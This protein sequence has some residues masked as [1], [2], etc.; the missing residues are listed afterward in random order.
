MTFT[1]FQVADNRDIWRENMAEVC[2][3]TYNRRREFDLDRDAGLFK[4]YLVEVFDDREPLD[5]QNIR[6]LLNSAINRAFQKEPQLVIRNPDDRFF[7]VIINDIPFVIDCE[8]TRF[9]RVETF[10]NSADSDRVMRRLLSD[11]KFI[12]QLW[13]PTN[14]QLSI[15]HLT[16]GEIRRLA[17]GFGMQHSIEEDSE[18]EFEEDNKT[19]RQPSERHAFRISSSEAYRFYKE[20]RKSDSL[21]RFLAIKRLEM[22]VS[23]D[24]EEELF[25]T[26]LSSIW[27]H[28]KVTSRGTWYEGLQSVL[29]SIVKVYKKGIDAVDSRRIFIENSN[30]LKR[31]GGGPI[32]IGVDASF[33]TPSL[34]EHVFTDNSKAFKLIVV[35]REDIDESISRFE[36]LDRHTGHDFSFIYRKINNRLAHL[37]VELSTSACANVVPRLVTNLQQHLDANATCSLFGAE[38]LE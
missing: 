35:W 10:V 27:Y 20:L 34:L 29:S 16:D 18:D 26:G 8:H 30:H 22:R 14:T 11:G 5:N 21:S 19:T 32:N 12:D 9:W 25:E 28:G 23:S 15:P 7:F 3:R 31:V 4:T 37:E 33:V 24:M 38:I 13:L 2:R 6:E 1:N 17:M 36:L